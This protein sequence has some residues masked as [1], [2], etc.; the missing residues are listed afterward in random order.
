VAFSALAFFFRAMQADGPATACGSCSHEVAHIERCDWLVQVLAEAARTVYWF[1]PLF[2]LLCRRLRAESEHA[3]DDVVLNAGINANDYAA[4]LLELAH[5]LRTSIPAWSPVL[6]MAKPPHLER[7]FVAMLNPSLN[8]KPVSYKAVLIACGLASLVAV[9]LAAVRAGEESKP[10]LTASQIVA[11]PA[12]VSVAK[13]GAVV[14]KYFVR[15][16]NG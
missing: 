16:V 9:P 1:N 5:T 11:A 7:R 15:C 14:R 6:S 3:C 8:R 2:W 12:V 4:H 13:S 10:T